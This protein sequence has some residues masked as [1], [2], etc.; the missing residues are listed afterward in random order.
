MEG[1]SGRLLSL[2]TGA[3]TKKKRKKIWLGTR[4]YGI[5]QDVRTFHSCMNISEKRGKERGKGKKAIEIPKQEKKQKGNRLSSYG[6]YINT[7]L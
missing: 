3:V 5:L 1:S 2:L 4:G 7:I 6:K